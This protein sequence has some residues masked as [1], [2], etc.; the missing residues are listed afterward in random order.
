[1]ATSLLHEDHARIEAALE[2]AERQRV[3]AVQAAA[4]LAAFLASL[5]PS[6]PQEDGTV[7]RFRKWGQSYWYAAIRGRQ[8]PFGN[9]RW[10]FTQD[11]NRAGGNKITPQDWGGLLD[12]V[13]E[14]N[15][16]TL[17]VLS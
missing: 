9:G 16:G 5:R 13:G 11:P 1:M 2:K 10:Y 15:W 14:R 4:D 8:D 17:E 3:A 12:K 6:E 7:V